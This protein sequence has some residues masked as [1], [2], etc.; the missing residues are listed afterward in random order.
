STGKKILLLERGDYVPREMANWSPR[1]V[2][3]EGK[4]QTKEVWHDGQGNPLHPHTNYCVGGNTKFYGAALFRLRKEA[5][6]EIR[7][8]GGISPAW[9][10]SYDE[11][12]PFYLQAERLYQVHGERG[13]DPTEPHASGPY[14]YPPVSHE[15]RMQQLSEDFARL[16][17]KPFH[18]PLGVQLDESNPRSSKCIRCQTCDG[19]SCLVDAKSDSQVICID[20]ALNDGGVALLTKAY[21]ERLETSSSGREVTN[22]VVS[23]NGNREMYSAGIY[24]VSCGAINSAALLLRSAND[25]HPRGLANSSGIVGRHYM[26]HV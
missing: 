9:P 5:F 13:T 25:K 26:G 2:N 11:L 10:I 12:E 4:Y 24:V 8:S 23:R 17:L 3:V 21:V 14:A 18:V 15:P 7:H 1:A 20:P 19:F 6:E 22:V 16:G